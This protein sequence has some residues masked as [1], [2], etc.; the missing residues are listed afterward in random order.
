M[1]RLRIGDKLLRVRDEP[2]PAP[3][4]RRSPSPLLLLHGAGSS[5]VIWIDVLRRIVAGPGPGPGLGATRRVIAPDL[6][7]HGQSDP[8][9]DK[10][11]LDGYR[12]AVGTVC[13][14]LGVPRA[15]LV[16]HSMGG[17]VAL[18]C[19][20]AWPERV[21]GLVLV[22]SAAR[23][24]V[25]DELLALLERCLPGADPDG[26]AASS[27]PAPQRIDRMPQEMGDLS[28]SP[29]THRDVRERWQA[30]LYA[31]AR[32]TVLSDFRAC[33]GIDLLPR[34][35]GLKLPTL[36]IGGE[37][38]LLVPPSLLSETAAAIAGSSLCLVPQTGHLTH[39][40]RPEAFLARL[41]SFLQTVP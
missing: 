30:V 10:P 26:E 27:W 8:W 19:A 20:L 36:I 37:D 12:D 35:G 15:V 16:G 18:S 39:L 4:P 17:A 14:K 9:H 28:F 13:A 7:G 25:S 33:R 38:D 41:T 31:A 29:S 6:P 5:S 2:E 23:L 34:L 21:A 11:S 3:D 22:N 1:R 24:D 40:E 32:E